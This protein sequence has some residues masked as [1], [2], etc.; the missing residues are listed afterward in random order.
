MIRPKQKYMSKLPI[1][2]FGAVLFF[3]FVASDCDKSSVNDPPPPSD[4]L[5][6]QDT[7]YLL[8]NWV[9][10]VRLD[11]NGVSHTYNRET[12]GGNPGSYLQMVY[13]L[14]R[15]ANSADLSSI[16][17]LY[18]FT[19]NYYVP[20]VTGSISS[21]TY[22]EDVRHEQN[23]EQPFV[24]SFPVI[25]Q[26]GKIFRANRNI[27]FTNPGTWH[28]GKLEVLTS[29]NFINIDGTNSRPDFSTAGDTIYFGFERSRSR[30]FLQSD[31]LYNTYIHSSD[32]FTVTISK[33]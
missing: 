1:S 15:P 5:V 29:N 4:N 20:G 25:F 9:I 6:I 12:S 31:S 30:S 21:L 3:T 26:S 19:G 8:D 7:E 28:K 33:E 13:N 10:Q 18:K 17:V 11:S 32:N 27:M 23:A 24:L 14:P 2:F 16:M 22:E